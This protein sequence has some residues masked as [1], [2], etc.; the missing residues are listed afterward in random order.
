MNSAR[1]FAFVNPSLGSYLINLSGE[2]FSYGQSV[3]QSVRLG[4]EPL[5]DSWP[6]FGCS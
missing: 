2:F 5:W 4:T 3:S 6:D 1:C